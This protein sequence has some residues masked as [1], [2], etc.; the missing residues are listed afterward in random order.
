MASY[1]PGSGRGGWS[2][3]STSP[4]RGTAGQTVQSLNAASAGASPSYGWPRPHGF[5]VFAASDALSSP[6]GAAGYQPDRNSEGASGSRGGSPTIGIETGGG[7]RG[8]AEYSH[9]SPMSPGPGSPQTHVALGVATLLRDEPDVARN[10]EKIAFLS[11][12]CKQN[13]KA[14][15]SNTSGGLMSKLLKKSKDSGQF[16]ASGDVDF[17]SMLLPSILEAAAAP[18]Y[19]SDDR[20][21]RPASPARKSSPVRAPSRS[22]SPFS[23]SRQRGKSRDFMEDGS[24]DEDD[25]GLPPLPGRASRVRN[26]STAAITSPSRR[27]SYGV[28]SPTSPSRG[29]AIPDE[30]Q[31]LALNQL[32]IHA[33]TPERSPRGVERILQYFAQLEYLEK[34]FPFESG[35]S[36]IHGGF[37]WFEAFADQKMFSSNALITD[38]IQ[39]EKGATLYNLAAL[40]SQLGCSSRLWTP[41]GLK[42]AGNYFQKA[43][44]VLTYVRNSLQPRFRI[45]LE[46][47]SD[48]SEPSLTAAIQLCLAQ[49]CECFYERANKDQTSKSLCKVA[50]Q[51][52]DLYEQALDTARSMQ[53]KTWARFPAEWFVVLRCK[54]LLFQA[55]SLLHT[56]NSL[57]D[58]VNTAVGERVARLRLSVEAAEQAAKEAKALKSPWSAGLKILV[59]EYLELMLSSFML[60]ESAN[61]QN[62]HQTEP[63]RRLLAPPPRPKASLVEA[64]DFKRDML[65]DDTRFIDLLEGVKAPQVWG[66]FNG[67]AQSAKET[68]AW[69]VLELR[70]AM[71]L[72]ESRLGKLD[73][74]LAGTG[75]YESAPILSNSALLAA[76]NAAQAVRQETDQVLAKLVEAQAEE[77]M[78]ASTD[79]VAKL[80]ELQKWTSKNVDE[81]VYILDH[82]DTSSFPQDPSVFTHVGNLRSAVSRI[83]SELGAR[84]EAIAALRNE[85]ASVDLDVLEWNEEKLQSVIPM[86]QKS[87]DLIKQ[88]VKSF[89]RETCMQRAEE[90]R[91]QCEVKIQELV[92]VE[93]DIDTV[94]PTTDLHVHLGYRRRQLQL[95][96]AD[97]GRIAENAQGLASRIDDVLRSFESVANRVQEERESRQIVKDFDKALSRYFSFRQEATVEVEKA[98]ELR[99]ESANVLA[100]C[101]KL[102]TKPRGGAGYG[103]GVSFGGSSSPG[104]KRDPLLLSILQK[105]SR[106]AGSPTS[107]PGSPSSPRGQRRTSTQQSPSQRRRVSISDDFIAAMPED[108]E[109]MLAFVAESER[110][111][112]R[113][114]HEAAPR[115]GRAHARRAAEQAH[116]E[117]GPDRH[118]QRQDRGRRSAPAG[119]RAS[120]DAGLHSAPDRGPGGCRAAVERSCRGLHVHLVRPEQRTDFG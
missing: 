22:P 29:P 116:V 23:M 67:F 78:L 118:Q 70:K 61:M 57:P 80:E 15:D 114:N 87:K 24:E 62:Y 109:E 51:T 103:G 2:F 101:L 30:S 81:S 117:A 10:R 112:Q 60:A 36:K 73:I 63:D 76:A 4:G 84:A 104:T 69:G 45:K 56:E 88:H 106:S 38:C 95:L 39:Y 102:P 93:S 86:L 7:Q 31:W 91:Q 77:S 20:Q 71:D 5:E 68:A 50:A 105:E 3:G 11:L 85:F 54:R 119:A 52:A 66:D 75:H 12:P 115:Q 27:V 48:L 111:G 110:R 44:G 79:V 120:R 113:R 41:E 49:A 42:E 99:K 47:S 13:G 33:G 58:P 65:G 19:P 72:V 14:P 59:Q 26:P 25:F 6:I 100:R 108:D 94:G 16:K 28:A 92:S 107:G 18:V 64:F 53:S 83:S 35:H 37:R 34:K 21:S 96:E 8:G 90:I 32:R 46:K 82:I 55:I 89:D 40:Y 74:R 97:V 9:N 98:T 43:A 1:S 17:K